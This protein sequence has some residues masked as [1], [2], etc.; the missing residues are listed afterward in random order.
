M[1]A[2]QGHTP[3]PWELLRDTDVSVSG[4]PFEDGT[5]ITGW[6]VFGNPAAPNMVLIVAEVA[7]PNSWDDELLDANSDLASAAPELLAALSRAPIPGRGEEM[8][9]FR[10]R[11]DRWLRDWCNPA[12][13]K[14][15]GQ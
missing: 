1:S 6:K 10:D 3:G 14:A 13:A 8:M 9:A 5:E 12:R 15:R 2:G 7:A 11:Q 4:G